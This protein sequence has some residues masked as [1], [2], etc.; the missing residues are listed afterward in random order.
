MT[1][2]TERH[3]I[4]TIRFRT[5]RYSP[6]LQPWPRLRRDVQPMKTA[7]AFRDYWRAGIER[8]RAEE[9]R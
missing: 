2:S 3:A 8:I 5:S 9:D 1:H 7:N 6:H 4:N